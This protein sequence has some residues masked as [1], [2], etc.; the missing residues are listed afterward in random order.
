LRIEILCVS[1]Q[2]GQFTLSVFLPQLA[3]TLRVRPDAGWCLLVGFWTLEKKCGHGG[4][5]GS[6]NAGS[7]TGLSATPGSPPPMMKLT[8]FHFVRVA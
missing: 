2:W 3:E 7:T 1:P 4:A 5:P 8:S 6:K